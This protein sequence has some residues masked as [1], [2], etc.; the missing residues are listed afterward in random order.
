MVQANCMTVILRTCP[1]YYPISK[2]SS[3]FLNF[4]QRLTT[5][6]VKILA[7]SVN[8]SKHYSI[9]LFFVIFHFTIMYDKP[10]F[11][12]IIFK[13]LNFVSITNIKPA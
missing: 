3:A 8:S 4:K 9:N 7:K 10:E 11:R 12:K 6:L 13:R 2:Q 1:R 5:V